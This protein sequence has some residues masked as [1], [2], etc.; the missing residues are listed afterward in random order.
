VTPVTDANLRLMAAARPP[1]GDPVADADHATVMADLRAAVC[2][3]AG[4][5]P[6]DIG[7]GGYDYS[8]AGFARVRASWL[9]HIEMFGL[10]LFD[11]NPEKVLADWSQ[12]RPE[13]TAGE[14]WR[15]E[16]AELHR[17]RYPDGCHVAGDDTWPCVVCDPVDEYV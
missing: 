4:V 2:L 10:G 6:E 11:E 16:G 5:A 17:V 15:A 13:F 12:V 8:A 1:T 9:R 14:D 3:A 7:P